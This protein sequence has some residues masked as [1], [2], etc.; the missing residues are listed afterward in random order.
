[1]TEQILHGAQIVGVLVGER[2]AGVAQCMVREACAFEVEPP[3]VAV[4]DL[5]HA[6]AAEAFFP[7]RL[8]TAVMSGTP[9]ASALVMPRTSS[10]ARSSAV[11]AAVF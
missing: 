9:S 8:P 7:A 3:Q 10:M 6:A 1:M 11:T 5:A 2:G 4:D